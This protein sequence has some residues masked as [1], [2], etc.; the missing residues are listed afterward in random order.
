MGLMPPEVRWCAGYAGGLSCSPSGDRS[1]ARLGD[2]LTLEDLEISTPEDTTQYGQLFTTQDGHLHRHPE[3]R[4]AWGYT[5]TPAVPT[6]AS[7]GDTPSE[8]GASC[9]AAQAR[10]LTAQLIFRCT[11]CIVQGI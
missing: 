2:P 9:G 10:L 6:P 1:R 3:G 4:P 8:Y 5:P 11:M 7:S